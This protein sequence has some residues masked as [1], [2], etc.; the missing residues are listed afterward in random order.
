ML[1]GTL[2]AVSN[3]ADWIEACELTDADTGEPVDISDATEIV[4]EIRSQGRDHVLQAATLTGATIAHIETGVFQWRFAGAQ[5]ATLRAGT[6]D[7]KCRI[8]KDAIVSQLLIGAL[9][10]LDG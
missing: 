3:Q 7:V 1:T 4:V 2:S 6:Y 9:P 5:M 10:V 8:T